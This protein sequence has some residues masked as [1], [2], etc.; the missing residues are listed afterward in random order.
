MVVGE[1]NGGSIPDIAVV[2]A[3]DATLHVLLG[4][5]NGTFGS[6]PT[7]NLPVG[8]DPWG[9]AAGDLNG[10]GHGDL[11]VALAESK[12]VAVFLNDRSGGFSPATPPTVGVG[13][14]AHDVVVADL[15][16]DAVLDLAV[17]AYGDFGAGSVTPL[18]GN[19][20]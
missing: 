7:V 9:V 11:V 13:A 6:A 14:K 4:L 8:S 19:A 3:G 2:C 10:D 20:R 16:G 12:A 18:L 17:L 5:G 1:F 15:T